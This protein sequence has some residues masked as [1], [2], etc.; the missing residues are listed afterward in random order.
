MEEDG[1]VNSPVWRHPLITHSKEP[2]SSP[3]TTFTSETLQAEAVKL[4]KSVQLFMSVVLD[5]SGIDYHVV[6]AQNAIQHCLDVVELQ[7]ELLAAL[8]KQTNRHTAPTKH[9]MP[10]RNGHAFK[11][12]KS[13]LL[14]ATNLFSSDCSVPSHGA[15]VDSKTNPPNTVFIQVRTN[16]VFPPAKSHDKLAVW[17]LKLFPSAL[18]EIPRNLI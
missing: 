5:S 16:P 1:D 7:P 13:F 11:H 10:V 14:N 15:Q 9:G 18:V 3:L 8:M 2:L 17:K 4:F 12:P 6:L